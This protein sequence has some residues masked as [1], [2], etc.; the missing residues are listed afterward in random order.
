MPDMNNGYNEGGC[1]DT[2]LFLKRELV[3]ELKVRTVKN[4][5][6]ECLFLICRD[7]ASVTSGCSKIEPLLNEVF[8]SFCFLAF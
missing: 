5:Y 8:L 6:K 2:T 3:D 7:V 4:V 1:E